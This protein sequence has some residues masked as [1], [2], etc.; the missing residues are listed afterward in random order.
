[1]MNEGIGGQMIMAGA[2]G[3]K[4]SDIRYHSMVKYYRRQSGLRQ[5]DL[6]AKVD[7]SKRTIANAESDNCNVSLSTALRLAAYF[8][9][10][11]D[12][13]FVKE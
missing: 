4:V 13:L 3:G 7:V 12:E 11:V 9:K 8:E 1:M 6:A 2:A 10:T 5:E